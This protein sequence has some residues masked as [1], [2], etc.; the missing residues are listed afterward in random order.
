MVSERLKLGISYTGDQADFDFSY[1]VD[2]K[3]IDDHSGENAEP[4]VFS[5][6]TLRIWSLARQDIYENRLRL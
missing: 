6:T 5:D 2:F 1:I 3:T 4:L